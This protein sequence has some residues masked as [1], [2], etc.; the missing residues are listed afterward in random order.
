MRDKIYV[1]VLNY[2]SWQDTIICLE[3]LLRS[4]DPDYQVVIIDN[5]SGDGS[6]ERII[7][8]L[9]GD[10]APP[11]SGSD[12]L[13][14]LF[15]PPLK[16]KIP[17]IQY[18][19]E[20]AE[21]GGDMGR[22]EALEREMRDRYTDGDERAGGERRERG[23]AGGDERREGSAGLNRVNKHDGHELPEPE[24]TSR[25]PV[26]LI[27]SDENRGYAGG[28]N[29]GI[30][31][32]L[33]KGDCSALW[34][35]NNDTVV[36]ADS[37][38]LLRERAA[39]LRSSNR[40]VGIIGSKVLYYDRPN[41][42]QS[43]GGRYN[44]WLAIPRHI[45]EG[46]QDSRQYDA[47]TDRFDYVPGVAMLLLREFIDEIGIMNEEYFLFFEEL[48]LA[49]RGARQGWELDICTGRVYHKEGRS[50]G[51][52]FNP[53]RRSYLSEFYQLRNRAVFT[54]NYYRRY[55]PSVYFGYLL[56]LLNGILRGQFY[57][58][59]ILYDIIRGVTP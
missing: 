24:Q 49:V 47:V 48:D 22:E 55:L 30:R 34:I 10:L 14:S 51:S 33:K 15:T 41:I 29:I 37:L 32:A 25:H 27:Q 40:R 28:N 16:K 44:R 56:S 17:F 18:T 54:R 58:F 46:D 31:H 19:A 6:A 35:L 23:A 43:V 12:P 50:T 5:N 8:W 42:I 9:Q 57:R 7:R 26:I 11:L 20:E 21:A 38:R 59:R 36:E 13:S 45:G 39:E 53:R 2:N 4:D 3:S 1:L 52:S